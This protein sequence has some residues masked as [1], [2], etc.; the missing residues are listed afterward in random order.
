MET[1]NRSSIL[2][3]VYKR[4]G[5]EGILTKIINDENRSELTE[6]SLAMQEEW[7]TNDVEFMISNGPYKR[8]GT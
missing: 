8:L 4:K 5:G 3:S 7:K 2:L 6:V 1:K